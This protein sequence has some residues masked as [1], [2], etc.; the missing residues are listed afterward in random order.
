[1]GRDAVDACPRA[2]TST[3]PGRAVEAIIGRRRGRIGTTLVQ[4]WFESHEV[5]VG[6]SLSVHQ[7]SSGLLRA[8]HT[9]GV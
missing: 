3:T 4:R 7:V 2:A 6:P 8:D 5:D 9:E 1:M